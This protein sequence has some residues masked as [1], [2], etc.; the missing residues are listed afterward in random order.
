MT[1]GIHTSLLPVSSNGDINLKY[2][3]HWLEN[4]RN[5]ELKRTAIATSSSSDNS[6]ECLNSLEK[7]NIRKQPVSS[8][9]SPNQEKIVPCPD[10]VLFGRGLPIRQLPGNVRFHGIIEDHIEQYE[11]TDS[12]FEKTVIAE[13]IVRTIKEKYGGRFLKQVRGGWG[14][15]YIRNTICGVKSPGSSLSFST[16]S[17]YSRTRF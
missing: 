8:A 2:H 9:S 7:M 17:I 11:K 1:F 12:R 15:Y 10:D 14:K 4:R 16:I 5:I 6:N 3:L 13:M